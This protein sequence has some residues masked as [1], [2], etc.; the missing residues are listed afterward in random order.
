MRLI[1]DPGKIKSGEII[2]NGGNILGLSDEKMNDLRG[3]KI[4]IIFQEPFT[5]L[6]PVFTAGEQLVES[7]ELHLKLKGKEAENKVKETLKQVGIND[8]ERVFKAYPHELSGGLRQRVMI[9]MGLIGSPALLI[10]DEP[11][12]A[13]DVTIQAQILELLNEIKQ[14]NNLSVLLITHDLGIVYDTADRVAVMYAGKIVE[15]GEKEAVFE[16]ALHPYTEG[17]IASVP[18]MNKPEAK[19]K[20]IEGSV[21]D[22]LELP[23]G[24]SFS[25]RCKY[26]M[27]ICR[28]REPGETLV[29]ETQRVR[30][31]KYGG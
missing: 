21:P 10:A 22:L 3:G 9:A 17:L 28:V 20:A 30:C 14:K 19:L 13:L 29:N 5:S 12:T 6:N 7:A 26:V 25:P 16:K 4:A 15:E 2:F 31:F 27:D 11:T 8:A 18:D 24:C 1:A 23:L